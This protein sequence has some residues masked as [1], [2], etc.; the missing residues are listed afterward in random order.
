MESSSGFQVLFSTGYSRF[1][2]QD[3]IGAISHRAGVDS[4]LDGF[5]RDCHLLGFPPDLRWGKFLSRSYGGVASRA[6]A[7]PV[8]YV[9]DF[10]GI[11]CALLSIAVRR[12]F[13]FEGAGAVPGKRCG[14][15]VWGTAGDKLLLAYAKPAK[16]FAEQFV[17][18]ESS[19]DAGEGILSEAQVFGD[20]L[21]G[22]VLNQLFASLEKVG[23]TYLQRAHVTLAGAEVRGLGGLQGRRIPGDAAGEGPGP[24]RCARSG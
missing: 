9:L 20:Q 6:C 16:D 24:H 4:R 13:P 22:S 12:C 18:A 19:G 7:L 1:L 23:V 2:A 14:E 21:R 10:P 3:Y 5:S 15:E 8:Y 11:G 17:T